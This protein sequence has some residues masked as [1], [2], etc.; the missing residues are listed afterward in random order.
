M[1]ECWAAQD[2]WSTGSI[3]FYQ[4]CRS[5]SCASGVCWMLCTGVG[6]LWHK[7]QLYCACLGWIMSPFISDTSWKGAD[8]L[9]KHMPSC[10][11]VRSSCCFA[12]THPPPLFRAPLWDWTQ[13]SGQVWTHRPKQTCALSPMCVYSGRLFNMQTARYLCPES[14]FRILC[15]YI[16]QGMSAAESF[17][18][19]LSLGWQ[20]S[21]L[22]VVLF[23]ASD[24]PSHL[25]PSYL[26]H[27]DLLN[28]LFFWTVCPLK[29]SSRLK[30]TCLTRCLQHV[31]F[32]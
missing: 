23:L 20:S 3:G 27:Q 10:Y 16:G 15:D 31:L 12:P 11:M 29:L 21:L 28:V 5:E 8:L 22:Y 1:S 25:R 17:L 18:H 2:F 9:C 4:K 7:S 19:G 26:C 30:V 24:I 13:W 6:H 14:L 32:T